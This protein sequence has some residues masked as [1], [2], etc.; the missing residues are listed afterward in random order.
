MR[1]LG[2]Q[3]AYLDCRIDSRVWLKNVTFVMFFYVT[4]HLALFGSTVNWLY[5][6][7]RHKEAL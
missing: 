3:V 1:V 6:E 2:G 5:C 4:G 7:H